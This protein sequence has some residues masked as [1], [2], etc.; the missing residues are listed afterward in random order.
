MQQILEKYSF[1]QTFYNELKK[2]DQLKKA[3]KYQIGLIK[4][5]VNIGIIEYL[6]VN[7]LNN[8]NIGFSITEC[9]PETTHL[10]LNYNIILGILAGM[11]PF[12]HH[13]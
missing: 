2:Q 4:E 10:E 9:S 7:E 11:I 12:P 6:D 1:D 3:Q 8:T 5:L 13:N